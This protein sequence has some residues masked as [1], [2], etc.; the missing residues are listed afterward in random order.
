MSASY[1]SLPSEPTRVAPTEEKKPTANVTEPTE[2]K[3]QKTE[4]AEQKPSEHTELEKIL[5]KI[6]NS[7][8]TIGASE[9]LKERIQDIPRP[10]TLATVKIELEEFA[11]EIEKSFQHAQPSL[12]AANNGFTAAI[13]LVFASFACCC[14]YIASPVVS[15]LSCPTFGAALGAGASA[16]VILGNAGCSMKGH[17]FIDLELINNALKEIRKLRNHLAL[18]TASRLSASPH[19]T[20]MSSP[21]SSPRSVARPTTPVAAPLEEA[22]E[23]A[24]L[25]Q[26]PKLH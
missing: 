1:Q 3:E 19:A 14:C 11:D 5:A 20:L 8:E 13:A 7:S 17:G 21:S 25:A 16:G 10:L 12:T 26:S 4:M 15:A 23:K 22:Q 24:D 18:Q 9:E 6:T 2:T